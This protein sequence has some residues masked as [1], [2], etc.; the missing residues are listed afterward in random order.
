MKGDLSFPVAKPKAIALTEAL[1]K[2]RT[3]ASL[4]V[5]RITGVWK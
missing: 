3:E 5:K 1:R 4:I 2:S